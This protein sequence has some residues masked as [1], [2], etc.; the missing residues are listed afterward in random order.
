MLVFIYLLYIASVAIEYSIKG[1]S[2]I[3]DVFIDDESIL[4]EIWHASLIGEKRCCLAFIAPLKG[5]EIDLAT[6]TLTSY[7]K[8]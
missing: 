1:Y 3:V 5:G 2:S 4:H 6:L 7:L 8:L